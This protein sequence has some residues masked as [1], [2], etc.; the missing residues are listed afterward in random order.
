MAGV[1][2][3][4]Q[5]QPPVPGEPGDGALDD[6]A[7]PAQ[8]LAGF[9]SFTGDAGGDAPVAEPSAQ[10]SLVIGLVRMELGRP[11][12]ARA[13]A[14]ADGRDSPDQGFKGESVVDVGGGSRDGQREAAAV[15][16]DVDL[17]AGLAPVN[18]AGTGQGAPFL[19][20]TQA[21]S[22]MARDQSIRPWEPSS[23]RTARWIRGQAPAL[24]HWAKRRCAVWNGTPKEGGRSR[25]AQPL[26]ST[27]TI[28]VNTWRSGK[29]AVPPPWGRGR[30]C[31]RCGCTSSQ[32]SSG[33]SR[34][35]N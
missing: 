20:R 7:V 26:V 23:S 5:G 10:V 32:S 1:A 22:T 31:G 16:Q 25:Q 9:D 27:Y 33:T 14:R 11:A 3:V 29:G 8:F 4:A 35:D 24:V 21:A 15:G 6:P 17:R 30:N 13:A 12:A 34:I 2:L 18:R 19:A 28:A